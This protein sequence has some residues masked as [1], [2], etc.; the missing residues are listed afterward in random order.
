M[1][2]FG[3]EREIEVG[4]DKCGDKVEG[5]VFVGKRQ[6]EVKVQEQT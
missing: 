4:H 3:R 6:Q 1:D 5:V 2:P